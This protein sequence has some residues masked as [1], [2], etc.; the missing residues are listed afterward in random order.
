MIDHL[1]F[2]IKL[3]KDIDWQEGNKAIVYMAVTRTA[4]ELGISERQIHNREAHL[5]DALGIDVVVSGN[6]RRYGR[7]DTETGV[8]LR[9]FGVDITNLR[10]HVNRLQ[11]AMNEE[12]KTDAIWNERKQALSAIKGRIRKLTYCAIKEGLGTQITSIIDDCKYYE[13]RITATTSV[14]E[15]ESRIIK[16]E[17]IKTRLERAILLGISTEQPVKNSDKT[18]ADFRHKEPSIEL[19]TITNVVVEHVS[20]DKPIIPPPNLVALTE[21]IRMDNTNNPAVV[22][23]NKQNW[24]ARLAAVAVCGRHN[25]AEKML[26]LSPDLSGN[27]R[28]TTPYLLDTKTLLH[29]TIK[30]H[31][32]PIILTSQ[33]DTA[34]ETHKATGV[35]VQL[36]W[37]R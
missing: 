16:A 37:I 31:T 25:N 4:R 20:V 33:R 19:Q 18:E 15:L 27:V 8:I 10:R 24:N 1:T 7:R 32:D 3:T 28:L 12:A 17:N 23:A 22:I 11:I 2:L 36:D 9:A 35:P 14:E 6:Y 21:H 5:I 13:G 34:G 30:P 29:S 26:A